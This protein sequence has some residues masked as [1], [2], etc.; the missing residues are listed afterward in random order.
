MSTPNHQEN[1]AIVRQ[2]I[3]LFNEYPVDATRFKQFVAPEVVWQEMP[4]TFC[5]NRAQW[6]FGG[7]VDRVGARQ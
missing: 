6:H 2:Y 4:N 5:S 3:A 7:D 1:L